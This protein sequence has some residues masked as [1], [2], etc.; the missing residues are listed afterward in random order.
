MK[1]FYLAEVDKH[2]ILTAWIV[3]EYFYEFTMKEVEVSLF[4]K[5]AVFVV[6]VF[7]HIRFKIKI[8]GIE[9]IPEGAAILAM[10]HTSNFDGPM[11]GVHTP[12]KMFIMGKEE[13]FKN[14]FFAKVIHELGCF[15]IKRGQADIKSLKYTLRILKEGGLFSIFIE[16]TRSKSGEMQEAKKGI[17]FIVA[18]SKAPVV[19]TYIY[20]TRDSWFKSAGVIFGK[21]MT[22]DDSVSHEEIAQRIAVELKKLNPN[23]E[24]S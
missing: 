17:G 5:I 9:N 11:V 22:F 4:Y 21:P 23:K 15:P 24:L 16:G 18:K 14:K 6:R 12:R 20:G 1:Y 13:L 7:L 3:L 19:P 2:N 8:I 10:N